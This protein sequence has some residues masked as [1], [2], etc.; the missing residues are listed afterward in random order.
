[1]LFTGELLKLAERYISD[2]VHPRI[3]A[4]GFDL[5]KTRVNTLLDSMRRERPDLY[6]DRELLINVARTSLRTK[7]RVEVCARSSCETYALRA[8]GGG[9]P[10]ALTL[11]VPHAHAAGRRGRRW[12]VVPVIACLHMF[13]HACLCLHGLCEWADGRLGMLKMFPH[14][15]AHSCTCCCSHI[16]AQAQCRT[17]ICFLSRLG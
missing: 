17:C 12:L 8:G 1:V 2:G 9:F 5:A 14:S 13:A 10:F 6:T 15:P 4:D 3:I 11:P 16:R 7:L